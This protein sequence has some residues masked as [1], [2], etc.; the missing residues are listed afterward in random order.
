MASNLIFHC[1]LEIV[2]VFWR[3]CDCWCLLYTLADLC[4]IQLPRHR[5]IHHAPFVADPPCLGSVLTTR[6]P[7]TQEPRVI[8]FRFLG[9]A[10]ALIQMT[11]GSIGAYWHLGTSKVVHTPSVREVTE[12]SVSGS[13]ISDNQSQEDVKAASTMSRNDQFT[14]SVCLIASD[15]QSHHMAC[16]LFLPAVN[17]LTVSTQVKPRQAKMKDSQPSNC[18]RSV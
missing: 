16:H 6:H 7:E 4:M 12:D 15:R 1:I 8:V 17:A 10:G 11:I 2:C 5:Y 9:E 14:T 18:I 3:C 13:D